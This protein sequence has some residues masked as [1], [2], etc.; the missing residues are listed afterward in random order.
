MSQK[1]SA[2][3]LSRREAS[4]YLFRVWGIS[5]TAQT[6][7]KLAVTGGGPCFMKDTRL[8]LYPIDQLDEW[9]EGQ[10]SP[11]VSSTAE[12]WSIRLKATRDAGGD[13]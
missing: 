12:L 9:A 11:P 10:L 4:E 1:L 2:R 5:R 8:C 3:P 13:L 7:A 6:L